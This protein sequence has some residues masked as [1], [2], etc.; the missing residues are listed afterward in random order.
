VCVRFYPINNSMPCNW[1]TGF[2]F[3]W[4]EAIIIFIGEILK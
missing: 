1:L 2:L 3:G 4:I